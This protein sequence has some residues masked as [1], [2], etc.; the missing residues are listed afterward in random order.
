M[1]LFRLKISL[2]MARAFLTEA[3]LTV[4]PPDFLSIGGDTN[5][6]VAGPLCHFGFFGSLTALMI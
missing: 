2:D 4:L 1:G 6:N 5:H 3:A